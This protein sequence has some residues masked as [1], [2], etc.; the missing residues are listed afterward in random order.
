V[1]L[2][3]IQAFATASRLLPTVELGT[4][5]GVASL[6]ISPV[7]RHPEFELASLNLN[8]LL[9]SD[10]TLLARPIESCAPV[11]DRSPKS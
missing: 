11:A 1:Q 9:E 7:V 6:L 3:L 10:K 4:E 5:G 8:C 2:V